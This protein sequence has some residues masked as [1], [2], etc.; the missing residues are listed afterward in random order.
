MLY[1]LTQHSQ[2]NRT[3]H[4]FLLCKCNPRKGVVDAGHVC[5]P[6]TDD[7]YNQLWSHSEKRSGTTGRQ[8]MCCTQKHSIKIIVMSIIVV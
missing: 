8:R 3:H 6:I 7:E 5:V 2:W 1:A 4:P